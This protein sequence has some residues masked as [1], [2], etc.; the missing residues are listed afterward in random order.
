MSERFSFTTI[1]S[2]ATMLNAATATT[3]IRIRLI[4]VFSMR[5]A[6]KYAACSSV[7]SRTSNPGPSAAA[8]LAERAGAAMTS[9]KRSLSPAGPG[10][11]AASAAASSSDTST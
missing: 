8:T 7:Q 5:I 11:A 10:P 2:A 1:T 4:I 3:S 9:S 6:R